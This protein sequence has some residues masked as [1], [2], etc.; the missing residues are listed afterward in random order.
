MV[1]NR[2]ISAFRYSHT[3]CML[4]YNTRKTTLSDS[5]SLNDDTPALS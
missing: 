1:I 2:G 4:R 5:S 3:T